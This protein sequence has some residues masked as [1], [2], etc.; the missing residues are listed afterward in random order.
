M[1]VTYKCFETLMPKPFGATGATKMK[2]LA[3]ICY[4]GSCGQDSYGYSIWQVLKNKFHTYMNDD[5]IRNVYHH[6]N[7]LCELRLLE[8]DDPISFDSR[9]IYRMTE[10]GYAY[11]EKY[12]LYLNLLEKEMN[13]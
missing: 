13:T 1:A 5:D 9:C 2:I 4:N 8:R 10:A 3:I 11:K 12:I 7:G 6:L